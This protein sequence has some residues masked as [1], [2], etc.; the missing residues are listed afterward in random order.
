MEPVDDFIHLHSLIG[1]VSRYYTVQHFELV[2]WYQ[3]NTV[4]SNR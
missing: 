2:A 1:G 3:E 4:K